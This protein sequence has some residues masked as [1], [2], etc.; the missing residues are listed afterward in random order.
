M[1]SVIQSFEKE[2]SVEY[3]QTLRM[4]NAIPQEHF[5]YSPHDSSMSL[6]KL[7]FHT[8]KIPGWA[9]SSLLEDSLSMNIPK[10]EVPDKQG[11]IDEFKE[12]SSSL[13][14]ALSQASDEDLDK[15]WSL[16][17][18][19]GDVVLESTRFMTFRRMVLNHL[20]HHRAQIGLYLRLLDV[21][22]PGMYGPSADE[23]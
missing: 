23:Q 14:S 11:I 6:G 12:V 21:P 22:V 1:S 4:L 17:A 10:Q 20:I 13:V 8:A 5:S 3:E 18:P 7:A 2:W 15:T 9:Q 19:N 16:I